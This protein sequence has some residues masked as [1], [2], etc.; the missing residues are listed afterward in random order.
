M[1]R[2]RESIFFVISLFV[3]TT[4]QAQYT[5]VRGRIVDGKTKEPLSYAN[6][7]LKG[8]LTAASAD[9]DGYYYLRTM[10]KSDSVIVTYLGYP[11]RA[12]AIK[13]GK[14]QE[15]N[16]EMGSD[17]VQLRE[18]VIKA[19]KKKRFV[20]TTANYV[21]HQ[22]VAHK[23]E[24]RADNFE[25]YRFEQYDKLNVGLVNPRNKF[26][27]WHIFDP[28][29][30][31]FENKDTL[32]DGQVFI[33]GLLQES[34]ADVYYR[35]KPR[36]FRK[37]IKAQQITGVNN[38]S[39]TRLADYTFEEVNC[40]D[41]LFVIAGKSFVGPFAP[42]ALVTYQFFITDTQK[43]EGR[44]TYKLHFVGRSK[45][46]LAL[47]GYAWIDSAK[48]AIQKIYF[49]PN[50]HANLNFIKDYSIA[51][52]FR[53]IGD[54]AW[55]MNGEELTT[56]GTLFK[57][58]KMQ[59]AIMVEKHFDRR[60]FQFNVAIPDTVF[61]RVD[62]ITLAPD[63][64]EKSR[65]YWDSARFTPISKYEQTVIYN[66]DTIPKVPAYK[67]WYWTLKLV[68]TA[69]FQAG[70]VEFGRF[71]KFVSRNNVE[72][73]R[74][75][76][77][78][79]TNEFMSRKFQILGYGAYGL[80]DKDFKYQLSANIN[81]PT[82]NE[83][84]AQLML[85]Y[86][87]DLQVLG[88]LNPLLT[89]DNILTLARKRSLTKIMKIRQWNV[90]LEKDWT[91][92]FSTTFT[93]G[94]RTFYDIPGVFDFSRLRP[95]GTSKHIASF[96]A[97]ELTIEARYSYKS[98][99]FRSGFYR[100]F[101]KTPMPVLLL[102][103]QMGLIDIDGQHRFYQKAVI[104]VR[105]R[106][107]WAMGH[108]NYYLEGGKTFGRTPYP[109]GFVVA[110]NYGPFL[111]VLNYNMTKEFEFVTNQYVCLW[112]EHHFDGWF[113]NKI[114]FVNR[115][116]LR[117]VLYFRGLFGTYD[118]RNNDLL[119]PSFRFSQ[120]YPVPYIEAGF[121]FENIFKL[122]GVYAMF[123]CTHRDEPG[124]TWWGIKIHLNPAF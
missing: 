81:L 124:T 49:R 85:N 71:Y 108:T 91:R 60:N 24:N 54:T 31:V 55:I 64:R 51:Q 2:I 58:K 7:Y 5:E 42:T 3:F 23:K 78:F 12:I 40:Y 111:D 13:R 69:Y 98:Q 106:F 95:D 29:R 100:Y 38:T 57:S 121:G 82:K 101:I 96:N 118:T 61:K 50:E 73:W 113:L 16:I 45:V 21:Y 115:L 6:I 14:S 36:T 19:G 75:R 102:K 32:E 90:A 47:K 84:W 46:D 28:F 11:R 93:I 66:N 79:R 104:T 4:T 116:Q 99:F 17:Q 74:L 15:L 37:F 67:R 68:T 63:A 56:E 44:T 59:M 25:N 72:G 94:N 33:R 22:V 117:E 88:Q 35:R 80:G 86:Q 76:L 112:F 83:R 65:E 119:Q 43:I 103:Y 107:S 89:F 18:V 8:T 34:I 53:L 87:Y 97:S 9:L 120:P 77:G 27:K 26:L 48:W 10:E 114:P 62:E 39:I 109:M 1:Q 41:D 70:P 52:H 105:H 122:F 20:D 123:R 110:G 30:F 92:D